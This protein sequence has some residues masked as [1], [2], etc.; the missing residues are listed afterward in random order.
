LIRR[1]RFRQLVVCS[2]LVLLLL[3]EVRVCRLLE[4]EIDLFS[5]FEA[6]VNQLGRVG[7]EQAYVV[8]LA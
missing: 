6:T 8:S 5:L 1:E 7:I 3:D 4:R 2:G